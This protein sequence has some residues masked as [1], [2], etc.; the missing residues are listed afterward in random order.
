MVP[1]QLSL[2]RFHCTLCGECCKASPVTIL[3][4]E[5]VILRKL[6]GML[7][8]PYKSRPGYRVYDKI[9]G[10]WIALSYAMQLIEGKC[11]FLT[12]DNLCMINSIYKPLICR[13]Y[14]YV[15]RE[16]RYIMN[17]QLKMVHATAEYGLSIKCPVVKEDREYL[18]R[19]ISSRPDWPI[20]YLPNEYKAAMEFE[21]KR[22]LLLRLLSGLWG[23]GLVNLSGEGP[24]ASPIVNLYEVLRRFYPNL[25]YILGIDATL[26]RIREE[27]GK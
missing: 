27:L 6:A 10:V 22:S 17:E 19:L 4:Y 9:H 1:R 3:P 24:P 20:V 7:G 12:R 18:T 5:D 26:R 16:I 14:P 2:K 13:S 21:E 11:T 23:R 25:P 8:R 15:P